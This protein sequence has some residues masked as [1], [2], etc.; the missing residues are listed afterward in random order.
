[1]FS[2]LIK[3]NQLL[4]DHYIPQ[5]WTFLLKTLVEQCS[6]EGEPCSDIFGAWP[7]QCS[8]IASGDGLYW[9]DILPRTFEAAIKSG[10]KVWPKVSSQGRTTFV[11]LKSSLIVAQGKVDEDVLTVLAELDLQLVQLPENLMNLV[12]DTV[13]KLIPSVTRLKLQVRGSQHNVGNGIHHD[14]GKT[15]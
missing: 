7:P 8:S 4:F 13:A 1:M 3:W 9:K 14:Q 2:I 5:A 15:G 10:I 12:D 11:D 6:A